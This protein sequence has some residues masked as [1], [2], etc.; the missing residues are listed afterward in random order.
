MAARLA[1]VT[2]A[3]IHRPYSIGVT[4]AD[5]GL[6]DFS[7]W[8]EIVVEESGAIETVEARLKA[9]A[10]DSALVRREFLDVNPGYVLE[11]EI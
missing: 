1:I 11:T 5:R 8:R 10:Y 7:A 9:G 4:A 2:R 3:Q 6:A